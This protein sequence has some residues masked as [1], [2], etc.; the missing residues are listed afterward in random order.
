[1]YSRVNE[2]LESEVLVILDVDLVKGILIQ[3][4]YN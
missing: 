4:R 2:A 1:M 3:D